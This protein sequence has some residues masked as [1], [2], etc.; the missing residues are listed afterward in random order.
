M[1]RTSDAIR[2]RIYD[3]A[4]DDTRPVRNKARKWSDT[5]KKKLITMKDAGY[6]LTEIAKQLERSGQSV[7]GMWERVQHPDYAEKRRIKRNERKRY[8]E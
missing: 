3:L 7:R 8:A 5:E 4:L 1:N 6:S 2:R